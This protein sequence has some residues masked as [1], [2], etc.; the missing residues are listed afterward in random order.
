MFVNYIN[1]IDFWYIK[2]AND[3]LNDSAHFLVT[4]IDEIFYDAYLPNLRF[5][6]FLIIC[7]RV[8]IKLQLTSK[9]VS[10]SPESW[11]GL[12]QQKIK[13]NSSIEQWAK[14][15]THSFDEFYFI[16]ALSLIFFVFYRS[17]FLWFDVIMA[18]RQVCKVLLGHPKVSGH[19][20]RAAPVAVNHV[21]NCKLP[22]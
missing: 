8:Y 13:N 10:A 18:L 12:A 9:L 4:S 2:I 20:L 5:G 15:R 17:T 16:L 14:G 21:K 3:S 11:V 6:H 22:F 7:V 1:T 19:V